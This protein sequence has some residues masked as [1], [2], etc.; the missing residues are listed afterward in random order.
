M[1]STSGVLLEASEPNTCVDLD[2]LRSFSE[3]RQ[4]LRRRAGIG[5]D[6]PSSA[7]FDTVLPFDIESAAPESQP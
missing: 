5:Q 4:R 2:Y 3:E 1:S 7:V 6:Q